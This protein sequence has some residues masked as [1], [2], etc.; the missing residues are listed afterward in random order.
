MACNNNLKQIG[1]AI[2]NYGQAQKVFPPGEVCTESPWGQATPNAQPATTAGWGA[3]GEAASAAAGTTTMAG[4][5][6]TSFLLRILPFIEGDTVSKNWNWSA[7]VS[8]ATTTTAPFSPNC[9]L[10]LAQTDMKGFYCPTRR[11][12]LRAGLDT[13]NMLTTLWTGGGTDY[14][15]CA[16]RGS[17]FLANGNY[18]DPVTTIGT[19]ITV[20]FPST[21]PFIP[22]VMAN[23]TMVAVPPTAAGA[24]ANG[25]GVSYVAG[26]F[27]MTNQ[28]TSFGA[29][30]DGLSNTIMTGEVQRLTPGSRDGWAIGGPCTLFTNGAM[31]TGSSGG[32]VATTQGGLLMN[33]Y[34]FGSPGSDHANGANMGLADGSVTFMNQAMDGNIFALMGSMAD[35]QAITNPN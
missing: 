32:I 25:V 19:T 12:S 13:Q 30:R 4:P 23:G 10:T 28:S 27:G 3:L 7:G 31:Y 1:L 11:S 24:I 26:V 18:I 5:Q 34:F 16:G 9:N 6:G 15:G 8:N 2:H 21:P 29:I 22:G 17:G 20:V 35:N 33:N 14:G